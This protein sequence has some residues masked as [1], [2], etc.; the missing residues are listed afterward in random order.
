MA[1]VFAQ[2]PAVAQRLGEAAV[3]V[4]KAGLAARLAETVPEIAVTT[5]AAAV[6]LSAPGLV[7]RVFGSRRRGP[8][9]RLAGLLGG[10]T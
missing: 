4:A 9:P 5:E 6:V 2:G 10:A 1:A 7:P 3:D 8:D